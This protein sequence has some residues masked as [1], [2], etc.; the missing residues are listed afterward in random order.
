[1]K[2]LDLFSKRILSICVGISIILLSGSLFLLSLQSITSARAGEIEKTAFTSNNFN[3]FG[4]S[5]VLDSLDIENQEEE[6][7]NAEQVFGIGIREGKLYFGILY[8]N[9]T[10]GLHEAPVDGEDVLVW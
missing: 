1:M 3:K 4:E 7:I 8:S 2:N 10:I 5:L 9:N 6:L